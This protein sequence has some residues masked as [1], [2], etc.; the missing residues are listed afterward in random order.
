M[1]LAWWLLIVALFCSITLILALKCIFI[2][3][4]S[5]Q[6]HFWNAVH[7]SL[8]LRVSSVH[9]DSTSLGCQQNFKLQDFSISP[10]RFLNPSPVFKSFFDMA[11][12][13]KHWL[14]Y[15]ICLSVETGEWA[16]VHLANFKCKRIHW[17][18]STHFPCF[19]FLPFCISHAL[20]SVSALWASHL[21]LTFKSR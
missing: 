4:C 14:F 18:I 21:S 10:K 3:Q 15:V 9:C 8:L 19:L 17:K 5:A 7:C 1:S 12:H 2:L 11:T 16:L 13:P 20:H 6:L